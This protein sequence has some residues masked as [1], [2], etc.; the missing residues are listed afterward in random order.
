MKGKKILITGGSGFIGSNLVWALSNDNDVTVIDNLST[1]RYEN[2]AQLVDAG[3]VRFV[4]GTITD[5]ALVRRCLKGVEYV[6]HEAAIPSVARSVK[7]PVAT[8]EANITGT[9]VL[10]DAASSAKVKRFVYASSSS[11]YGDTEVSPKNEGLPPNPMSPY[12]LTKVASEYYCKM[13]HELHGL[14]T[15]C[16]RYFNVYGPR[17]DPTSEYAAV[18][19]KF[20]SGVLTRKPLTVFG[21]GD[22]TRDFTFVEDIVRANILAAESDAVGNFNIAAGKAISVHDLARTAMSLAG[23]EVGIKYEPPNPG[24]IRHSLADISKASKEFGYS[25]KYSLDEGLKRTIDWL[26]KDRVY[27]RKAHDEDA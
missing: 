6:F 17:Q 3:K 16:L 5:A 22:Q 18:I 12:A 4:K 25:P 9:L 15:V 14:S 24:D 13:F 27:R 8:N 23:R 20:I 10:L 2:V 7:D 11:V 1:G 21:D 26:S 19:P